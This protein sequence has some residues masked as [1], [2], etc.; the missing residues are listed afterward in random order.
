MTR[1]V[2]SLSIFP[3][4]FHFIPDFTD[5][6]LHDLISLRTLL[7]FGTASTIR[8]LA[9]Y[10]R[11]SELFGLQAKADFDLPFAAIS[12]LED[13][14]ERP[15]GNWLRVDPVHLK[16]SPKGLVLVDSSQFALSRHDALALAASVRAEF[17]KLNYE[18][19]V[20]VA[21]R[22]YLK[23]PTNPRIITTPLAHV[24]GQSIS[25]AL[26]KGIDQQSWLKLFN[27][28]QMQL[29]HAD[30][31]QQRL[32]NAD[33]EINSLWFWGMGELPTALDR[34]WSFVYASDRIVKGLCMLSSSEYRS[35]EECVF[36]EEIDSIKGEY[37]FILTQSLQPMQY[38]EPMGWLES[39]RVI[40]T[41]YLSP[42]ISYLKKGAIDKLTIL[43]ESY[44]VDIRKRDLRQFWKRTAKLKS[45]FNE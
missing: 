19:E 43:T 21:D 10:Q 18:L 16:P 20:P 35:L 34:K 29:H 6:E 13:E 7:S 45:F 24:A 28:V 2:I 37:L 33:T 9:Y 38:D 22:W 17:Q 15:K 27:E 11:I 31:N 1:C 40:D 4:C 36:S 12:L 14:A 25:D 23:I 26:C 44:Q 5:A 30:V 32:A 3:V 41:E 39:S 8:P 42:L